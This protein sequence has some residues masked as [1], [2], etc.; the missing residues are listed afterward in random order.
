LY[1]SISKIETAKIPIKTPCFIFLETKEKSENIKIK[2][3]I[4]KRILLE[5]TKFKNLKLLSGA[6]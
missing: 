4:K 6:I 5:I 3:K 1:K 2:V